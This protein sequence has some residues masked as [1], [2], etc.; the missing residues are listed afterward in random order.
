M[1]TI[2]KIKHPA[3]GTYPDQFAQNARSFNRLI[4]G[5]HGGLVKDCTHPFAKC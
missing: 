4:V 3:S 1:K 5:A 2:N